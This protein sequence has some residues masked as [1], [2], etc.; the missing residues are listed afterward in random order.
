LANGLISG[1][2]FYLHQKSPI[3]IPIGVGCPG[4]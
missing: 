4:K 1:V 2:A 3:D